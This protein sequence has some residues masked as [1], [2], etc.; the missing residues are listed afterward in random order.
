MA[1]SSGR[2]PQSRSS[3]VGRRWQQYWQR[4]PDI[5]R[6]LTPTRTNLL[7]LVKDL[8]GIERAHPLSWVRMGRLLA[9]LSHERNAAASFLTADSLALLIR[10]I[11]AA[12]GGQEA[13]EVGAAWAAGSQVHGDAGVPQLSTGVRGHQVG[14]DVQGGHGLITADVAGIGLQE[15]V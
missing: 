15:A 7:G 6:P 2:T 1:T 11:G 8:A 3:A 12:D 13:L 5:R 9:A 4:S 14:I 10:T